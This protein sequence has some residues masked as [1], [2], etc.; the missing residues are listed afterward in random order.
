M[1]N[2]VLCLD[3]EEKA[4]Y[5]HLE[6]V[7]AQIAIVDCERLAAGSK[8]IDLRPFKSLKAIYFFYGANIVEKLDLLYNTDCEIYNV[9]MDSTSGRF[10][11]SY[12]VHN[13]D[14]TV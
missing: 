7:E 5:Y 12:K 1:G 6:T 10:W 3:I 14:H 11:L 9:L 8:S 13:M 4:S 2:P